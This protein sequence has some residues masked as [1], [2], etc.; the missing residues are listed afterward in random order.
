MGLVLSSLVILLGLI[1]NDIDRQKTVGPLPVGGL[2]G[3]KGCETRC[4]QLWKS[5]PFVWEVCFCRQ[6][7]LWRRWRGIPAIRF[8]CWHMS[9]GQVCVLPKCAAPM[10]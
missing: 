1:Y 2:K 7:C 9:L 10:R 8:G 5:N 4:G 3:V 6:M